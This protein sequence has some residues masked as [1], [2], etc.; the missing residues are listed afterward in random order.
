MVSMSDYTVIIRPADDD[1]LD[2]WKRRYMS[3]QKKKQHQLVEHIRQALNKAVTGVMDEVV[4]KI[5][6]EE[7]RPGGRTVRI[8]EP[9]IWIGWDESQNVRNWVR[10]TKDLYTLEAALAVAARPECGAK[11]GPLRAA[12]QSLEDVNRQ[13]YDL[14]VGFRGE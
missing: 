2:E 3:Q 14:N 12:V 5:V 1:Q 4:A 8:A 13:L 11:L 7:P 9:A 6:H 10:K